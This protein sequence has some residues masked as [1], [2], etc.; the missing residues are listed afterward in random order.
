MPILTI[1]PMLAILAMGLLIAS[2]ITLYLFVKELRGEDE[3]DD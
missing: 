2:L 3:E 1:L